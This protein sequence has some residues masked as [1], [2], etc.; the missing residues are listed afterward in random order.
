MERVYNLASEMLHID[1]VKEMEKQQEVLKKEM[2][3]E[4][5]ILVK[6]KEMEKEV[7]K[8][9]MEKEKED[10][11]QYFRHCLSF[12]SQRQMLEMFFRKVMNKNVDND[13][14]L[15]CLDPHQKK[16]LKSR[17]MSSINKILR[18]CDTFRTEMWKRLG[19]PED[20]IVRGVA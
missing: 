16:Q 5:K 12:L 3:M 4:K 18:S 14:I 13:P 2:E 10:V 11:V 19:L 15:D 20:P 9:D 1:I 7:L 8:K 6:E 17:R